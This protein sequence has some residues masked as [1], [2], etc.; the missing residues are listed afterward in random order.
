MRHTIENDTLQT[1]PFNHEPGTFRLRFADPAELQSFMQNQY[2]DYVHKW[3][4][5][6]TIPVAAV[7]SAE[8]A[9]YEFGWLFL[10][11]SRGGD[12]PRVL[13]TTSDRWKVDDRYA[14][15]SFAELGVRLA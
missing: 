9:D 5:D 14:V 7:S 8:A 6:T 13:V 2:T 4:F 11:W 1:A 3:N 10:D 12:S 15:S